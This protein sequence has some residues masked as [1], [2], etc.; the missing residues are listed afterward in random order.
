[1]STELDTREWHPQ[2]ISDERPTYSRELDSE[3]S[4]L[5]RELRD[6]R[7]RLKHEAYT[8]EL[9]ARESEVREALLLESRRSHDELMQSIA[10]FHRDIERAKYEQ[11]VLG[12]GVWIASSPEERERLMAEK[13][14]PLIRTDTPKPERIGVRR[15]LGRTARAFGRYLRAL[16]RAYGGFMNVYPCY[17]CRGTGNV[18][19]GVKCPSCN[20]TGS[21][22]ER[23]R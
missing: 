17:R 7:W 22:T 14:K 5:R 20:G 15:Q 4:R 3:E 6:I 18:A 2:Y 19:P 1:M 16:I 9:L 13:K 10:D 23:I 12:F 11:A 8:P 21:R